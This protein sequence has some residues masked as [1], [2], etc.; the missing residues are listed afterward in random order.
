MGLASPPKTK[1][2][3]SRDFSTPNRPSTIRP[4]HHIPST[5]VAPEP[6]FCECRPIRKDSGLKWIFQASDVVS[7]PERRTSAPEGCHYVQTPIRK[8]IACTR[9]AAPLRLNFQKSG[10]RRPKRFKQ[11]RQPCKMAWPNFD[12]DEVHV[13]HE[14]I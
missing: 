3:Y 5:R 7:F 8:V 12:N 13:H 14:N 11:C 6:T 2:T 4:K 1:R 10:L 9:E